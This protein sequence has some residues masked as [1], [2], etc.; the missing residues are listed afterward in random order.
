MSPREIIPS[1]LRQRQG[2]LA[3]CPDSR[4]QTAATFVLSC[5]VSHVLGQ[6]RYNCTG[7][8]FYL[9]M[10][11]QN[12]ATCPDPSL[13][14]PRQTRN[15]NFWSFMCLLRCL[16]SKE[17]NSHWLCPF[18]PPVCTFKCLLKACYFSQAEPPR[19]FANKE[20]QLVMQ[21]HLALRLQRKT[22]SYFR[23]VCNA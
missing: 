23:L 18:P 2:E 15:L 8:A 11:H 17:V 22:L 10:F 9:R 16:G 21:M 6:W 1:P 12:L 5:V 14:R 20:S 7:C 13:S 19:S 4:P 3:T